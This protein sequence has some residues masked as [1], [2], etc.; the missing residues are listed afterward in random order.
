MKIE[1][2]S[3]VPRPYWK[4]RVE[5][6][7]MNYHTI[8]G[9]TYW[10]EEACYVLDSELVDKIDDATQELHDMCLLYVDDAIRT[11]NYDGYGFSNDTIEMID[12]SWKLGH[13]NIYGRFDLGI[14]RDGDLKMFEYN[15]DTPTSLLEAS[16]IQW[17]WK[18]DMYPA[19]DQF[20][21]IHEKL[22]DLFKIMNIPHMHFTTMSNAPHEDWGNLHYLLACHTEAGGKS[23]SINLEQIGWDSISNQFVDLNDTPITHL[24]KLYPWEWMISDEFSK[25]IG[26]SNTFFYEPAW[27]MLLSNKLL[28]VKLW[29][30]HTNHPLLLES[31]EAEANVN[32][33]GRSWIAKPKL[34]REG[35]GVIA[36]PSMD[37]NNINQEFFRGAFFVDQ[38]TLL[39][40]HPVIGSWVIGNKSGGIGI[41]EDVGITTNNSTFVPHYFE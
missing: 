5:Q 4:E 12:K 30:R 10:N 25:N 36:G 39:P 3:Y 38:N 14:N 26:K 17:G 33:P 40:M 24:F 21:S 28:C 1:R 41:R 34:G 18:E 15:A 31:Y 2:L 13:S 32:M 7:G 35:Q 20:N 19:Y 29:E 22:V 37:S 23:S 27:K 16:V 11:G 8:D 6:L 9:S